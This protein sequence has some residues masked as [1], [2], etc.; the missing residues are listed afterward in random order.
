MMD[1]L[2]PSETVSTIERLRDFIG[3]VVRVS[4]WHTITQDEV[5]RFAALTGEDGWI[6]VDPERAAHSHFGGTIAQGNLLLSMAPSL[7]RQGEG[8]TIDLEVR[9]GLNYGLNRV[10]YPS[11]VLVNSPIRA[12]LTLLEIEDVA[13]DVYQLVWERMIEVEGSSKPA[14][15]AESLSRQFT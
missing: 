7:L 3:V 6:H 11:S 14:M 1:S 15:V 5:D 4:H 9:Y 13:P 10:R 12:Q 8:L 2:P